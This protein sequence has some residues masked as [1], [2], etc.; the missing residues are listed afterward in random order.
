MDRSKYTRLCEALRVTEL[1][2]AAPQAGADADAWRDVNGHVR[3]AASIHRSLGNF[4]GALKLLRW[5]RDSATIAST[6]RPEISDLAAGAATTTWEWEAESAARHDKLV[7]L[8]MD[9]LDAEVRKNPHDVRA[10]RM[11]IAEHEE[12]SGNFG[13]ASAQLHAVM[14]QLPADDPS[15][16]GLRTRATDLD[17]RSELQRDLVM[18]PQYRPVLA[19]DRFLA[20]AAHEFAPTLP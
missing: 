4:N 7:G 8:R 12:A 3:V 2:L 15:I 14:A 20:E 18:P 16:N 11:Q 1:T 6:T 10:V 9:L 17:A 19:E 5:F 13:E